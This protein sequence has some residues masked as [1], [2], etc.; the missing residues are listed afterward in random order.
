MLLLFALDVLIWFWFS[1]KQE[2][3]DSTALDDGRFKFDSFD[4]LAVVRHG[5][6]LLGSAGDEFDMEEDPSA[7]QG[8]VSVFSIGVLF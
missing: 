8:I 4:I 1:V 7:S 2:E 5:E 6:P 3:G